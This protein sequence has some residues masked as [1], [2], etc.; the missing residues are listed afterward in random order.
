M[1]KSQHEVATTPHK[2][3][4][5]YTAPR[6]GVISELGHFLMATRKWWLIPVFVA[7]AIAGFLIALGSTAAAPFI[8]TIF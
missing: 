8:Y 1:A 7:L 4:E 3:A 5:Q 2:F 6:R